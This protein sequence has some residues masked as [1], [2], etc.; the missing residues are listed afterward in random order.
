MTGRGESMA[1]ERRLKARQT[2]RDALELKMS[3]ATYAAI[4]E[5]LGITRSS[6]HKAVQTAMR[7]MIA[8]PA[9][10]VRRMEI[11]RLDRMAVP[12]WLVVIAQGST[13]IERRLAVETLL[14]IMDR[15]ARLLGLDAPIKIDYTRELEA[16]LDDTD[17]TDDERRDALREASAIIRAAQAKANG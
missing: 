3:G 5:Q 12:F 2:K 15:R 17:L 7:E 11:T 6:A 16:S 14:K 8:E 1:S 13:L 9:E 4:A 10:E